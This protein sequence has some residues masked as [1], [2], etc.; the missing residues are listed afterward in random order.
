ML[1]ADRQQRSGGGGGGA[2]AIVVHLVQIMRDTSA[3][4]LL[5]VSFAPASSEVCLRCCWL[6][7]NSSQ[8]E[9]ERV[10]EREKK[11]EKKME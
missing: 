1:G 2:A 10:K 9:R 6:E 11:R 4:G 3:W 8:T 5:R 7:Q